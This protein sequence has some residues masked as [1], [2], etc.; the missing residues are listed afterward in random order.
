MVTV[1]QISDTHLRAE[2]NTPTDNDPDASLSA[3]LDAVRDGDPES[4]RVAVRR[5]FEADLVHREPEIVEAA[6]PGSD[7]VAIC[8]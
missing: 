4:H 6:D 3:T 5:R 2:P 7:R 1:L 8:G